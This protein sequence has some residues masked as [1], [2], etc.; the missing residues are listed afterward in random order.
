MIYIFSRNIRKYKVEKLG[1][2][3]FFPQWN[4]KQNVS[5]LQSLREEFFPGVFP[6]KQGI[7]G[8]QYSVLKT[9]QI[10]QKKPFICRILPKVSIKKVKQ[11]DQKKPFIFSIL[12]KV[13]IKK[14]KPLFFHF[15]LL[16]NIQRI[17][18]KNGEIAFFPSRHPLQFLNIVLIYE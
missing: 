14:V 11:I 16:K 5:G 6:S 17:C 18:S 13:N 3:T 1:S 8:D 15:T 12:I 7:W 2:S 4:R 9:K 10:D